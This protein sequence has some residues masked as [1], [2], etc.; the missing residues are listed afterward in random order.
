MTARRRA[1]HHLFWCQPDGRLAHYCTSSEQSPLPATPGL[2]IWTLSRRFPA[3]RRSLSLDQ[4]LRKG[5]GALNEL[6]DPAD[7]TPTTPAARAEEPAAAPAMRQAVLRVL[8]HGPQRG[9]ALVASH[10][11]HLGDALTPKYRATLGMLKNHFAPALDLSLITCDPDIYLW[12]PAAAKASAACRTALICFCTSSNS[13]NTSLPIAQ[14]AL[15]RHGLAVC[16]VMNRRQRLT[17]EGLPGHDVATSARMLK[18]L[19]GRLGFS[20]LYGLGV[21]LGGYTALLYAEGM[22]L[23]RVLNF[24][25]WP[26]K[27]S[28][29]GGSG[30]CMVNA[31]RGFPRHRILT[32]LSLSDPSDQKILRR[33]D[34]AGF[35]TPRLFLE[36]STHGTFSAAIIE[37]RLD[38]L[39]GWLLAD[40]D[41]PETG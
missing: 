25:G 23:R 36:S 30:E 28:G 6:A 40:A 11:S 15:A 7:K 34:D 10:A 8:R 16:Y 14:A 5:N 4:R 9:L 1:I 32:V 21:S 3:L 20:H 31:A 19:L 38:G 37:S 27:A 18:A 2:N 26:D 12:R 24:S 17:R 35:E 33:Y 39:L 22:E 41:A 29:L 13:L